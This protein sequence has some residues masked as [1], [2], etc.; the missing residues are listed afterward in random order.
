MNCN[1]LLHRSGRAASVVSAL[2]FCISAVSGLAQSGANVPGKTP[3]S[4]SSSAGSFIVA[5]SI[6]LG[7]ASSSVATGDLR[8]SG[9]LDLVTANPG[10]GTVVVF[11]GN[12]S[13][14][15][16][17]G[18]SYPAGAQPVAV[19]IADVTGDGRADLIVANGS[20]NTISVLAGRGDGSFGAPV[21][22]KVGFSPTLLATGDFS[23]KGTEEVAVASA[24]AAQLAILPGD[25]NG[26]LGTPH[27]YSLAHA[28]TAMVASDLNRDGHIDLALANPNGTI[29]PFL[30]DGTG[31]LHQLTDI[32]VTAGSLSSIAAADL[33]HDGTVDLVVTESG[34]RQVAVLL[35]KGEGSFESPAFFAVGAE[36][37]A[38]RIGD[39]D[40]DGI[41]D[42]VVVNK[43]SNTF[44]V[45]TGSGDG[46]FK[47]AQHFIVGNN[48]A[49]AVLGG[50]YSS[51]HTDLASIN[52]LSRSISVP[53]GNGDGTFQASRSYFT[54]EQPVAVASADLT[55]AGHADLAV[56]NYCGS[57]ISCKEPGSVAILLADSAGAYR[58]SSVYPVGAGAVAL[59]LRDVNGDGKLDLIAL[60]RVDKTMTLRLG[61]GDGVFGQALTLPLSGAPVGLVSGSFTA[62][63]HT[64]LAILEDCGEAKC[65]A[66]GSVEILAGDGAGNFHSAATFPVGYSPVSIAAGALAPKGHTDI[67]VL[68]RCGSDASCQSSGTV[69]ILHGDGAGN[70]TAGKTVSAGM[71]P[72]SLALGALTGSGALDL[73]ISRT[74]ANSLA[75]LRGTGDGTFQS[76]VAYAAGSAPGALLIGDFNGDGVADVAVANASDSTVSVLYGKGDGTLQTASNFPVGAHPSAI[77]TLNSKGSKQA[78]IAT[79]N[80]STG[81]SVQGSEVTALLK[82][83]P[84]IS[85]PA[86]TSFTLVISPNTVPDSQST[87][88]TVT[89]TG[90]TT[91]GKPLPT[92][93]VTVIAT[94]GATTVTLC[95]N[96]AQTPP[97][98]AGIDFATYNCTVTPT[99]A[100]LTAA[101]WNIS[102]TYSDGVTYA[103]IT[104]ATEASNNPLE[105][106]QASLA[107]TTV[108]AAA[109]PINTTAYFKVTLT[110]TPTTP[111]K[112]AGNVV[113]SQGSTTLCT[114]ALSS[115][116]PFTATCSTTA[117]AGPT[118]ATVMATYTDTAGNF[119]ATPITTSVT[120]M[121]VTTTLNTY[122]QSATP[123]VDTQAKFEAVVGAARIVPYTPTGTV[124]FTANGN[125]IPECS[126]LNSPSV[127]KVGNA[128]A[129]ICLTSSLTAPSANI[130]ATYSGDSNFA[131][132]TA[133]GLP[134]TVNP[135]KPVYTVTAAPQAPNASITVNV[136]VVFTLH[137]T[138]PAS[139]APTPLVGSVA[140]SNSTVGALCTI[141]LPA[142]TCTYNPGFAK[143]TTFNTS[144]SYTDTTGSGNFTAVSIGGPAVVVTATGTKTA[145][146]APAPGAT[147]SVF[148]VITLS[149]TVTSNV[150]NALGTAV[151]EGTIAFTI[152]AP[153]SASNTACTGT[154]SSTGTTSCNTTN[155]QFSTTGTYSITATYNP[156]PANFTTSTTASASTILIGTD[157]TQTTGVTVTPTQGSAPIIVNQPIKLSATVTATN[158][159]STTLAGGQVAFTAAP[160]A[161]GASVSLCT[162][163]VNASGAVSCS[164]TTANLAALVASSYTITAAYTDTSASPIF[165]SS[166]GT[167]TLTVG[168]DTPAVALSLSSPSQA[169]N[170]LLTLSATVTPSYSGNI[171]PNGTVTF[172]DAIAGILCTAT[173]SNGSAS[174]TSL[175]ANQKLK[176]G[177]YSLSASYGGDTATPPNFKTNSS[178]ASPYKVTQGTTSLVVAASPSPGY[179]AEPIV[180]TATVTATGTISSA[181]DLIN[182]LG[183]ISFTTLATSNCSGVALSAPTVT[184][185]GG[186]TFS[187]TYTAPCSVTYAAT[188][189]TGSDTATGSLSADPA[190]PGNFSGSTGSVLE[191]VQNYS[192][193]F[194]TTSVGFATITPGGNTANDPYIMAPQTI[195]AFSVSSVSTG[196]GVLT[197]SL[198][199]TCAVTNSGGNTVGTLSCAA[200]PTSVPAGTTSSSAITVTSSSSST[201]SG[202][203]TITVTVSNPKAPNL[204]HTLTKQLSVINVSQQTASFA[205]N[206]II[207]QTQPVNFA[208]ANA[209]VTL[210]GFWCPS[211]WGTPLGSTPKEN[212][213]SPTATSGTYVSCMAP[214]TTT[215]AN[216]TSVSVQ[217]TPTQQGSSAGVQSP[218]SGGA[219]AYLAVVFGV[220]VLGFFGWFGRNRA[221]KNLFRMMT[222]LMLAWGALT[223]NGCGGSYHVTQIGVSSP[224]T[225]L[226]L[227]TYDVLVQA[228]GS[229]NNQYFALVSVTVN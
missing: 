164:P 138:T 82:A 212:Q 204:M 156:N 213:S 132:F 38:V 172:S 61:E 165:G 169:V 51:G 7:Y 151:P 102:A 107:F 37:V 73:V 4:G 210:S 163:T 166:S 183:T 104:S 68:N 143:A 182:P 157:P 24:S 74:G 67:I 77:A 184:S 179:A 87:T 161:G 192:S 69:S 133:A 76:P 99:T 111:T 1:Q 155:K 140:I 181:A 144:T 32:Q 167:G 180:Y 95:N 219:G 128:Y 53:Q 19:A 229:D 89:A 83:T 158:I 177:S 14:K 136:P 70:F 217:I 33:N 62:S 200:S 94:S 36:P 79:T 34:S 112:P 198:T 148:Q 26:G 71:N 189:V 3:V 114:S 75:V 103:S 43:S 60:N 18:V 150:T 96:L 86:L 44:S 42:L 6:Y 207:A 106:T 147:G 188:Y 109:V 15:F 21:S 216:S 91:H 159:G 215:T 214:S 124:S 227:G 224:P 131:G 22:Y 81:G 202:F 12:G 152:T 88:V 220:P 195:A 41:L 218:R 113:F 123:I 187:Y 142:T 31:Q 209:G 16:S 162:G 80:G 56:A 226:P 72:G 97:D 130:V 173:I 40:G 191:G 120:L 222:I 154:V 63:G 199:Y 139:T 174:C 8:A 168:E 29:T 2:F 110:A 185:T 66:A 121:P 170:S 9:K 129:A 197:D 78:G 47:A 54:G 137:V 223:I 84:L 205:F 90:D 153:N 146:T 13:G 58:L 85:P 64:D 135:L 203:Y 145:I 149:A 57:D 160:A 126:G 35:G 228:T 98:M 201:P 55:G 105:V 176:V 115:S 93:T 118:P 101:T 28:P 46:T 208:S 48:P 59:A 196:P 127:S 25:G 141:V 125:L 49:G 45:L 17:A 10:A 65:P 116:A 27:T 117:L 92:A 30:N 119:I 211:V 23:G 193:A 178:T 221:R 11:L 52:L 108:P 50:F 194:T 5:P 186:G 175:A 225:A 190:P 39:V 206:G 100:G 122:L 20:G 171:K 134:V